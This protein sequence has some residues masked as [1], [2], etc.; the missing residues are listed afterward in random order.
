MLIALA[1]HAASEYR[2]ER[3][4]VLRDTGRLVARSVTQA[5]S[6][7]VATENKVEIQ[8]TLNGLADYSDDVIKID[9]TNL[10][11]ELLA[12]ID[13]KT[14][15]Q[16]VFEVQ[17]PV[18]ASIVRKEWFAGNDDYKDRPIETSSELSEI[19]SVH[20]YLT[21]D[22]IN[23]RLNVKL[24]RWIFV[25]IFLYLVAVLS[26]LA[27]SRYIARP[28]QELFSKIESVRDGN[29]EINFNQK[30]SGEIGV[31]QSTFKEMVERL[32][33]ASEA[34]KLAIK[35]AT[36][37]LRT[38]QKETEKANEEKSLLIQKMNQVIE[39]DRTAIASEI[40][41]QLNA[42]LIA[43]R[44]QL[45]RIENLIK[46]GDN[47]SQSKIV[48]IIDDSRNQI[49]HLYS[50]SRNLVKRL[51]PE[52]LLEMGLLATLQELAAYYNEIHPTCDFAIDLQG[53]INSIEETQSMSIY[54]II[55][56]AISNV[57]KH[58]KADACFIQVHRIKNCL[59]ILVSDNGIG[60]DEIKNKSGVGLIGIR[61]RTL[62]MQGS[63]K[64]TNRK[65][66]GV[67]LQINLNLTDTGLS[68]T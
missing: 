5:V 31:I 52:T 54:R 16:D 4:S 24:W 68:Q 14:R 11:G 27:F 15:Y 44:F 18:M 43:L 46:K 22:R 59:S 25:A 36:L 65:E 47:E 64:L 32:Q 56:E 61:E 12:S 40:H 48:A 2:E 9:V 55:Q 29:F 3:A 7:L 66:G 50:S 19:G 23:H 20:I 53:E 41:D 35:L 34:Q 42:S 13:K 21:A 17:E 58:S 33:A 57:I 63:Y 26:S 45:D 60:I 67:L 49:N 38:Q 28:L 37:K 30:M 51:I 62:Q 1:L 10:K 8:Q 39:A 6:H